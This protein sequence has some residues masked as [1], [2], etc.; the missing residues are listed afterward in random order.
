[1]EILLN[2]IKLFIKQTKRAFVLQNNRKIVCAMLTFCAAVRLVFDLL[3][4]NWHT[5][6]S[7]LGNG[8][9]LYTFLPLH[10]LAM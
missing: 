5:G 9:S 3:T 2:N 6:Y 4:E 10:A 7:S 8:Y 1:M